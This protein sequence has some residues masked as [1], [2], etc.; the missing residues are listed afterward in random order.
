MDRPAVIVRKIDDTRGDSVPLVALRDQASSF[1][2]DRPT[3]PTEFYWPALD[4]LRAVAVTIVILLHCEIPWTRGGGIGVDIFFTL[5]GFLISSVLLAEYAKTGDIRIGRFYVRR[6]LRLYP[7]L[8]AVAAVSVLAVSG[9]DANARKQA[10]D[11]AVGAI[12]YTINWLSIGGTQHRFGILAHT[13]SLAVEEQFYLVWPLALLLVLRRFQ[14]RGAFWVSVVLTVASACESVL[15]YR[16]FGWKRIYFGTDARLPQILVGATLALARASWNPLPLAKPLMNTAAICGAIGIAAMVVSAPPRILY[17]YIGFVLV[18][19]MAALIILGLVER[20]SPWA[21]R[22]LEAAPA[23]F[24]GR[25]SYGLYLWHWPIVFL[26]N[27]WW[28]AINPY[29]RLGIVAP[30]SVIVSVMSYRFVER[31]FLR[32][33]QRLA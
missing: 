3:A 15:L 1:G 24:I 29:M 27:V 26:V 28:P 19:I 14:V 21:S 33:K 31:P 25:I 7:A 20:A 16:H 2:A 8:L 17:A 30:L 5:S 4:G 11:G 32:V 22:V 6:L 10:A 9:L 18:A 23:V 13:W 12:T